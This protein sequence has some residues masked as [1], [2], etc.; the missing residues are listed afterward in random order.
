[1]IGVAGAIAYSEWSAPS[2]VDPYHLFHVFGFD[3]LL[4]VV[5]VGLLFL[6]STISAISRPGFKITCGN[7]ESF[8][9]QALPSE[10]DE[11]LAGPGCHA[12]FTLLKV[13]E[14]KYRFGDNVSVE[15]MAIEPRSEIADFQENLAWWSPDFSQ[16]FES[17]APGRTKWV[18]LHKVIT[19]SHD[20]KT[21]RVSL[22]GKD[23]NDYTATFAVCWEGR[24][25]D[26]ISVKVTSVAFALYADVEEVARPRR[27]VA[28]KLQR[29]RVRP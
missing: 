4:G 22:G 7:S 3:L 11:R 19:D 1:M 29:E 9:R 13:R 16:E 24:I 2:Q 18:V 10:N 15:V 6:G 26:T 17:F 14:T 8:H 28:R 12:H 5:V 20:L 25:L 23:A 27:M 21:H